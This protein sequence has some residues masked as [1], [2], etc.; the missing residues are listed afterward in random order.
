VCVLRREEHDVC[1]LSYSP[2]LV[3]LRF[4]SIGSFREL[5]RGR[6][7]PVQVGRYK[8]LVMISMIRHY[9]VEIPWDAE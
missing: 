6:G 9:Q 3:R 2:R 8:H 7:M 1:E 4:Q 5:Q